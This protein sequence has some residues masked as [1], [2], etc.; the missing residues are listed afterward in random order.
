M[1]DLL[2]FVSHELLNPADV[3]GVIFYA[4]LFFG[5]AII[6]GRL[7]RYWMKNISEHS[8][9][10]IDR[11][12]GNFVSELLQLAFFLIAAILYA[13]TIPALDRLRTTLLTGAGVISVVLGIAAQNTLGNLISGIALLIYRPFG[14][15]DVLA[16]TAPTG[17]EV[18][19]VREFSLGYTKLITEDGRW[20]IAPNSVVISSVLVRIK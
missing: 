17:K 9:L 14:I 10:F 16:I 7:V 2:T 15:G 12:S 19:T 6:A 3:L 8:T 18:G 11:T 5:V 13:H 20:I 4:V 1:E